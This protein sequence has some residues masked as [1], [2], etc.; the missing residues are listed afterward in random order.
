M[1]LIRKN[2]EKVTLTNWRTGELAN[3]RVFVS[4]AIEISFRKA[5]FYLLHLR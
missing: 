3:W 4:I 1:L 2:E 5:F